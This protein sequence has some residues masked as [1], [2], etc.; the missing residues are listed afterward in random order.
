MKQHLCCC[1]QRHLTTQQVVII[2]LIAAGEGTRR[3]AV[4]LALSEHTI[5]TH[6]AES[7]RAAGAKNRS[8]LVALSYV[9]GVL[10][11]EQWPPAPTG[12][13]C[14]SDS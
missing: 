4:A 10:D 9:R 6:V 14:I 8:E 7:L 2:S 1:G 12:K 11:P 5:A 3:I 13:R